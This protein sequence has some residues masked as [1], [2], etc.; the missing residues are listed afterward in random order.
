MKIAIVGGGINGLCSAWQLA[1]RGHAVALFERGDLMQA[2]SRSSSKLLHGGLRYL[3]N[4]EFRL[5]REALRE[6]DAWLQRVPDLAQPLRLVLPI[7]QGSRRGRAMI[8]LGLWLYDHIAGRSI[9]PKAQWLSRETLLQRDPHLQDYGLLGGYA[10]S[11]G[12]MDD[13]K[14]GL[15]VAAQA[16]NAGVQLHTHSPVQRIA[17]TGQLLLANGQHMQFDRIANIAGPWALQ[18]LAQSGLQA[19]HRLDLVRGSHLVLNAPCPQAYLLE[20]PHE[21][22]IFFVLPWQ[23]KTLLGTTEVRQGLDAP[24]ACSAQERDYLLAAYQHYRSSAAPAPSIAGEFAGLRPLIY[25]ALDANRATREY[26]LER[27]GR[28]LSV[29]GGKW[30]TSMAL[31]GKVAAQIQR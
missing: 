22:R 16:Q 6:R 8:A 27:Q 18:L 31:A 21:R 29:I 20:V 17:P 11:D 12:H 19:E 25:S 3:E 7:Y 4:Y 10:Y 30:T 2:T 24:I 26:A 28:I 9:L 5:V 23:G 1:L 13:E 14:L 15:W